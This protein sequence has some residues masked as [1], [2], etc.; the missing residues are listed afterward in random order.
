MPITN[1]KP[2]TVRY[3][4]TLADMDVIG[5]KTFDV[6]ACTT[7]DYIVIATAMKAGKRTSSVY[8]FSSDENEFWYSLRIEVA[9]PPENILAPG[10]API[11]KFA[12]TFVLLENP[13]QAAATFRVENDS[14]TAWQVM[15]KRVV[16]LAPGAKRK[17]ELRFLPTAVGLKETARI[18]FRSPDGGDYCYRVTG[19]GKPP[20][21]L[22]PTLV[23]APMG[24]TRSAV[25]LFT[26]P[27]PCPSRFSI[28]V[29]NEQEGE[30]FQFLAKRKV[31]SLNTYGEEFQIPFA[32]APVALGQ[33]RA[34]IIV[35]SL[36]PALGP[37]PEL[38]SLPSV[39]WIYPVIG[40]AAETEIAQHRVLKCRAQQKLDITFTLPLIGENEVFPESEYGL[41]LELPKGYEFVRSVLEVQTMRVEKS[42]AGAD[43]TVAMTFAPQRPFQQ[44]TT[45]VIAN[46][47]GQDWNFTI[48][49]VVELGKPVETIVIE[50]LLNK[51]GSAKVQIPG[52]FRDQV[53]FHAYFAAGSG[54]EFSLSAAHGMIEPTLL[55]AA[56]LPVDVLFAP[57]MYGKLQK[58]Y[59]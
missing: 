52:V 43:L 12:S 59:W 37:L 50:S 40:H 36:G 32:F 27:F 26:N 24:Q 33:F 41:R 25:I 16:Q 45:V 1:T 11:G 10:T 7:L 23:S 18:A 19:T 8:F 15:A 49:L 29:S 34:S 9:E 51:V 3:A 28:T 46:P 30:V 47:L 4:I 38:E 53:P 44:E 13:G 35:A 21:P 14:Q 5:E 42:D 20:Q 31:F 55:P 48:E 2:Y 6:S 17:V 58:G 56:E 39:R 22:S 57:K 54:S